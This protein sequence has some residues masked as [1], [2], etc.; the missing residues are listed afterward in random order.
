MLELHFISE[1]FRQ[2]EGR[3]L[4]AYIPCFVKPAAHIR[5]G[6]TSRNFTGSNGNPEDYEVM[7]ASGV[8]I[9]T[10]C[11]LGQQT[12][13]GMLT[14]GVPGALVCRFEPYIG[15]SGVAAIHALYKAPFVITSP[16]CDAL[17]RAIIGD[18]VRRIVCLYNDESCVPFAD[19]PKE[20][21]AV[22]AHLFY[23]KGS[24]R[25][26]PKTWEALIR[27]NW[28]AAANNLRNGNLWSG[29]YDYGR[30]SEGRLLTHIQ[31]VV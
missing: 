6:K 31:G 19:I 23:H 14:M 15:K 17:D 13:G 25:T 21:Q 9:G 4:Q 22:V 3:C 27:Q 16:E 20:A 8:T 2:W 24:P 29:P 18:Y 30:A 7:G 5:V 26:F 10:G 12:Y 11:D 28:Q 1:Q